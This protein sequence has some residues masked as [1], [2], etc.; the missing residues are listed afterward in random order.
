MRA[1]TP[2]KKILTWT[3]MSIMVIALTA[4]ETQARENP[5]Q[6]KVDSQLMCLAKNI[7]YE[8]GME[9]REGMIA[10]AQVTLNR[11]EDEKFPKTICAVVNQKTTVVKPEQVVNVTFIEGS[12]Y[13]QHKLVKTTETKWHKI[14]VC[15]FSWVCNT[16]APVRFVSDRWQESLDVAKEVM[17]SGLRL[18]NEAMAEA[19]YFHNT[20]V[21]PNWGLERIT[22]I[23]GHI[24]YSDDPA[25]RKKN[26]TTAQ[27]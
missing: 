15:Q 1:F 10:V 26:L 13:R 23:G 20:H 8:A 16:P 11:T 12:F 3:N 17:Y 7:Y 25:P 2:L 27:K 24:F 22:R 5:A 4:S 19:L 21:R 6:P 14:N 18:E 9:T